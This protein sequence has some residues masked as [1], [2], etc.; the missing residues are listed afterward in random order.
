MTVEDSFSAVFWDRECYC[1]T[2]PHSSGTLWGFYPCCKKS[3]AP[4]CN[5][6]FISRR[7]FSKRNH[8]VPHQGLE[9]VFSLLSRKVVIFFVLREQESVEGGALVWKM[10]TVFTG[11]NLKRYCLVCLFQKLSPALLK[12]LPHIVTCSTNVWIVFIELFAV[13][14]HQVNINDEGLQILIS[15]KI[16]RKKW[17]GDQEEKQKTLLYFLYFFVF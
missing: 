2:T 7:Y 11:K 12:K 10:R 9:F 13:V 3:S 14:K 6:I 8:M 15:V 1:T 16:Q 17:G 4:Q 5:D